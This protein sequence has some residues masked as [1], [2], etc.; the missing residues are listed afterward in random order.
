MPIPISARFGDDIITLSGNT[1]W[2]QGPPLLQH[3]E[4]IGVQADATEH[5]RPGDRVVVANSG[6]SLRVHEIVTYEGPIEMAARGGAVTLTLADELDI[7][8]GDVL[9]APKSRPEVSEQFAATVL[10][11]DQAPLFPGLFVPHPH[12]HQDGFR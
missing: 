6:L 3:L 11:M 5:I 1:P 9:V 10:W 12:R 7:T 4:T 2:Y 8:R